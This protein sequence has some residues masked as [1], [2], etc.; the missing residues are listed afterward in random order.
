[1]GAANGISRHA[2][3]ERRHHWLFVLSQCS[4]WETQFQA[5]GVEATMALRCVPCC[6]IVPGCA[7]TASNTCDGRRNDEALARICARKAWGTWTGALWTGRPLLTARPTRASGKQLDQVPPATSKEMVTQA[8][9][10][11]LVNFHKTEE[12]KTSWIMT[13]FKICAWDNYGRGCKIE[14]VVIIFLYYY[15]AF[16]IEKIC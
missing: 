3:R 12:W 1:M 14:V 7:M 10:F 9:P 4:L 2:L 8:G 13:T 16:L 15:K 6:V 11:E 5:A